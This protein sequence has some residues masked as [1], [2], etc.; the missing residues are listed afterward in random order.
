MVIGVVVV[1][2]VVFIVGFAR[3]FY[4]SATG[5]SMQR[6][7]EYVINRMVRLCA[8]VSDFEVS[9]AKNQ[10]KARLLLGLSGS[11][12]VAEELGRQVI[13]YGRRIPLDEMLARIDVSLSTPRSMLS[14]RRSFLVAARQRQHHPR[15]QPEVLLR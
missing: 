2:V 5:V 14:D 10:L 12:P 1:V 7:S 9:R 15:G 6:I 11:G 13:T 8:N 3:G 4:F